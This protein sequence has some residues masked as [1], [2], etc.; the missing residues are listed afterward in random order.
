MKLRDSKKVKL[1]LNMTDSKTQPVELELNVR[2]AAKPATA[3]KRLT[4]TLKQ[5]WDRVRK[6][7]P[8]PVESWL[9][10]EAVNDIWDSCFIV[11]ANNDTQEGDYFYKY[12]GDSIQQAY[13]SELSDVEFDNIVS[14]QASHLA[15]EYEKVL[16]M[17][18]P[19]YYEGEIDIDK[20]RIMKYRQILLPLGKDGVN[21]QS[22][23]G[24]FS[25]K[26]YDK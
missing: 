24:G 13:S 6:D 12:I 7:N 15:S 16:A 23:M 5:Y 3:E 2:R 20:N 22:I 19:I 10:P 14:T 25:Y 8:F 18:A 17:K 1:G 4:T 21:I 26:I 9:D 11:E